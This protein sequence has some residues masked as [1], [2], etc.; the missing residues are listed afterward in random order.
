MQARKIT[1]WRPKKEDGN[2][3]RG[4]IQDTL[5]GVHRGAAQGGGVGALV[6]QRVNMPIQESANV[7][8]VRSPPRME[9]AVDKV[10]M[11]EPPMRQ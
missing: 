5:E 2:K 7:G 6:V 9:E 1:G 10:E 8:E 3:A 11:G 4:I